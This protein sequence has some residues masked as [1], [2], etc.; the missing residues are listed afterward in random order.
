MHSV[1]VNSEDAIAGNLPPSADIVGI[2]LRLVL[3]N[4]AFKDNLIIR[5][6]ELI[7]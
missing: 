5:V 7:H 1:F 2:G 4:V 6:A 3:V